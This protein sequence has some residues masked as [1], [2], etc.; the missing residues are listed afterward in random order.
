M[1]E[2]I[3]AVADNDVIGLDNG[4]PWY[5]KADMKHFKELTLNK[6]VIMGSRTYESIGKALPNRTNIIL[7]SSFPELSYPHCY[8]CDSAHFLKVFSEIDTPTMVIGGASVYQA[9]LPWC[10]KLHLTRVHLEPEGDTYFPAYKHL[11]KL[12]NKESHCEN[13]INFDFETW[14]R[15]N[16][17][18]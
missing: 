16:F 10:S 2:A 4:I 5:I 9:L 6:A 14:E 13:N 7:S 17:K 15:I 18:E 12:V 8:I 11:F 1:L 3:V